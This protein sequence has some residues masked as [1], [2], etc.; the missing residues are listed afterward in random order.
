MLQIKDKLPFMKP[1]RPDQLTMRPKREEKLQL[2][3]RKRNAGMIQICLKEIS[4]PKLI[5]WTTKITTFTKGLLNSILRVKESK[6]TTRFPEVNFLL[7]VSTQITSHLTP[8]RLDIASF[9]I[10]VDQLP[11]NKCLITSPAMA[12]HQRPSRTR[13]GLSTIVAPLLKKRPSFKIDL[14]DQITYS[15]WWDINLFFKTSLLKTD[16][17]GLLNLSVYY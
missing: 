4:M 2:I 8:W 7:Q 15:F 1:R 16:R 6:S 9:N 11:S 5:N 14:K 3:G 13:T 10:M 17:L 12:T